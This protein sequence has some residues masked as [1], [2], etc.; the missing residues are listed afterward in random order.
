MSLTAEQKAAVESNGLY[1]LSDFLPKRPNEVEVNAIKE[2]F[3]SSVDGEAYDVERFGQYYRPYGVEAPAGTSSTSDKPA[4]ATTPTPTPDVAE[5]KATPEP[6]P[7]PAPVAEAST[8]SGGK[9]ADDILA[10]IRARQK[11]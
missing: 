9:S 1:N 7:E 5:T 11:S 10:M 6:A 4:P 3:E 2:M 8:E